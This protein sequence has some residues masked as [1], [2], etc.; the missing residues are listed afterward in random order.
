M[1]TTPVP[2]SP[3]TRRQFI[4]K[5]SQYGGST[6]AGLTALGLISR[7]SGQGTTL[8]D[9]P[10]VGGR[11]GI[12]VVIAGAGVGGMAAAYE[13]LKLGFDVTVLEAQEKAGG[14]CLTIRRGTTITETNGHTQTCAF[15][16]GL[17]YNPGPSRFPQWHVTMD[18]CR[19]LGVAIEPFVSMNENAYYY[20]DGED[21]GPLAGKSL[22]IREI[23][24]DLRGQTAELLAKVVQQDKLDEPLSAEDK[25]RMIEF[26]K[27][28]GGLG[29]DLRYAGH[30]RRGYSV[31]PAVTSQGEFGPLHDRSGILASGLWTYFHRANDALYQSQM[32]TPKG[33][34][35]NIAQAFAKKLNGKIIY[36]AEVT[37]FRRTQPGARI[38]YKDRKTGET[39][40]LTADY[41]ICNLTPTILRKVP[42]DFSAM[43]KTVINAI[44]FQNSGKI[45][46]QFKRRFWEE[47]DRIFGGISWT[48]LPIAEVWYPSS[49]FLGKKGI[50]GGYYTF[51]PVA[52][53][54]GGM[55][56]DERTEFALTHGEK[57]HPQYRA[58]FENAFS[59]NWATL[60]FLE[61]CL[62][63]F[64]ARLVRTAYPLITRAEGELYIVGDWASHL[65]GW[66]AGAF[67]SA[68]LAVADIHRR[69]LA[70]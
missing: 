60:P 31:W 4:T 13:L 63:H 12:K 67:E 20:A 3:L 53:Q 24:T 61:G 19:E 39:K 34:M 22:R 55:T 43:V 21:K 51:G 57:M 47:D 40:E 2:P 25:E 70:A 64:P 52:D 23:K 28:E 16:E 69:V 32:F 45:G 37:E 56:P 42:N 1:P 50:I 9:L 44:P 29:N 58:E 33:G 54:L 62:S 7:A 48:S 65:G 30:N 35:D 11:N 10:S 18:Y 38:V 27:L 41:A 36:N 49:D 26:L 17:Y 14:R 5:L 6:L 46:M 8:A 68:R 66:Q 15:D 59:V